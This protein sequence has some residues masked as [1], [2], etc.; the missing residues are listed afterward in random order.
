MG[1]VALFALHPAFGVYLELGS[2]VKV[3]RESIARE[4]H[5]LLEGVPQT[6]TTSELE[7]PSGLAVPGSWAPYT[8]L[9]N[10]EVVIEDLDGSKSSYWNDNS[11]VTALVY[12][13]P[14]YPSLKQFLPVR[15][16]SA[17]VC[18]ACSGAGKLTLDTHVFEATVCP[19]CCGLGWIEG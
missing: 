4:L 9:P 1:A 13:T 16:A 6:R 10:C 14:R 19:E 12:L 7:A 15:G 17:L 8:L 3:D 11:L 18:P 5:R 2:T